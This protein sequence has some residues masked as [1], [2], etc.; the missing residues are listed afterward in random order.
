LGPDSAKS[1]AFSP[2]GQGLAAGSPDISSDTP[3]TGIKVFEVASGKLLRTF[4]GHSEQVNTVEFSADGRWLVSGSKD[5]SVKIW[6]MA[7]G[8]T[9]RTLKGGVGNVRIVA[10]LTDGQW[11]AA[12][13]YNN[14]YAFWDA[15]NG[16]LL[17]VFEGAGSISPSLA[18]SAD[19]KWV[20][21]ANG[22][23]AGTAER[24]RPEDVQGPCGQVSRGGCLPGRA[25][26]R[27]AG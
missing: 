7:N 3:D 9:L 12:G 27:R 23:D 24:T 22:R 19:R 20:V 16:K 21:L 6:N 10:I 4:E 26:D 17:K 25:F 15:R 1:I 18:I 5:F 14:T 2:D 8:E 13:G 11:I